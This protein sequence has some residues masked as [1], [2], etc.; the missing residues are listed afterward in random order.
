MN[1][2]LYRSRTD[3]MIAGVCGGLA[4]YLRV[5]STLVRLFFVLLA[6]GGNGIGLLA[7][8]HLAAAIPNCSHLE[9]PHD[10]PSGWTAAARDQMLAEPLTIDAEGCVRVPDRPGFGFELDE[11]RI[12]RYTVARYPA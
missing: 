6:L 5:D 9:F 3:T 2:K 1:H 8:L 11:E 12:D 7:N 10:P 4:E